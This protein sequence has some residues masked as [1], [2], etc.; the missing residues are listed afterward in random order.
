MLSEILYLKQ[1]KKSIRII[2]FIFFKNIE[3]QCENYF[4][5]KIIKQM[6]SF[7]FCFFFIETL[8]NVNSYLR[9]TI[10]QVK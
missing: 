7:F 6:E 1:I 9:E 4:F 10:L 8:V 2:G 5:V 3:F